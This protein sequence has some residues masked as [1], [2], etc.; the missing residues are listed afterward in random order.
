MT[1]SSLQLVWFKRDLRL[2]DSP[3][4][5]EA[6]RHGRVLPLCVIEPGLWQQPDMS[7]RH[8]QFCRDS[9]SDL[10]SDLA[11]RGIPLLIRSTDI[12]E[13]LRELKAFYGTFTL[14]S[15]EETGNHWT[16]Q[17]D[18]QVAAWCQAE[19][20][21]WHELPQ[22]GVVRRLKN[23]D[24][25]A[26]YRES[27]MQS[28][29]L[30][31]P[32]LQAPDILPLLHGLPDT[33][34]GT[35]LSPLRQQPGGRSA[36]LRCLESFLHQRGRD[37]RFAMSSPN[38]A[39]A[40]CSRLSPHLCWGTLSVREVFQAAELAKK[41]SQDPAWKR[42]LRSFISRL[43]WHCHFMQ[44]L[45][46]M[47]ALE[48]TPIHPL[49][50]D[51]DRTLDTE[52]LERWAKGQTG[53]PFVDA[54][55]R[56]LNARGWINF[57]MRAMLTSVASYHLWL[58]WQD[59]GRVLARTF[60]DYEP[61]IHWPQIQMQ[62]GTTGINAIRVYNPLK[63]GLELDPQGHFIRRW[64]PELASAPLSALHE[65]RMLKQPCY[66]KPLVD[67]SQAARTAKDRIA[68]IHRHPQFDAISRGV[69]QQLGS[70]KRNG[71]SGRRQAP[72]NHASRRRPS[73]ASPQLSLW[74]Q[75]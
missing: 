47:P 32:A 49:F 43:Y 19:S 54:C 23:R 31:V 61:G 74:D 26:E 39:Y 6:A 52:R 28:P 20:I 9:L 7:E 18:L 17:R 57:R 67:L 22:N 3:A 37:Y 63:Q 50:A 40:A 12:L 56:A 11:A 41:H 70:R 64:V 33:P 27:R 65:P 42:S 46:D 38:T 71:R 4:L 73:A 13:A 75:A 8:W 51:L 34:T 59:S 60:I 44:K 62:S 16:Y 2:A 45:E 69:Y 36:G 48:W 58:P 55:M 21:E 10:E 1:T 25:W 24:H 68:A 53:W 29:T 5:T 30:P 15:H 66:P 14:W 72:A 35:H